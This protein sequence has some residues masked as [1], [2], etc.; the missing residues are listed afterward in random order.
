MAERRPCKATVGGSSPL[1]GFSVLQPCT[2]RSD[3]GRRERKGNARAHLCV[4]I[5]VRRLEEIRAELEQAVAERTKLWEELSQ[6][7]DAAKSAQVA[8][9][10]ARINNLWA[11]ER[12]ARARLRFGD[13]KDILSR[14]RA[15]DRLERESRRLR[16]A[17]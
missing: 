4:S 3:A 12:S 9:L 6:A 13:A 16:R 17:A 7:H 2:L 8:R 15:E 5:V 10:T 1:T 14:A 11:E